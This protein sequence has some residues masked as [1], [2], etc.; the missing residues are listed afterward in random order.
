M[1]QRVALFAVVMAIAGPAHAQSEAALRDYFEGMPVMARVDLPAAKAG[2]DIYP[3]AAA[4]INNAQV[5]KQLRQSGVA[6]RRDDPITIKNLRVTAKSIELEF[7]H[8]DLRTS[9]DTTPVVYVTTEES[10]REKKLE[11][12][13]DRETDP[14]RR[15][16]MQQDL[17]ELILRR[18]REEARLKAAMAQLA[19]SRAREDSDRQRTAG[20]ASRFNLL[21][22]GGIPSRALSPEYL[23]S[24]L[25]TWI[26]FD[27]EPF[28]VAGEDNV[29]AVA[30]QSSIPEPASSPTE[31]RKGLTEA[32]L[33]RILGDPIKRE[34]HTLG[35]LHMEL[36]T[37][38]ENG[39]IVE[40]TMV[41][42]VLVRF[43]QSSY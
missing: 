6:I 29:P 37:F 3:D 21:F 24:A 40:A 13:I 4:A 12:D 36:L 14:A 5:G 38:R 28:P 31:L 16:K 9:S 34:P 32:E 19:A 30:R 26:D 8:S 11:Q 18:A 20:A 2:V 27:R 7:G 23:M 42:G 35:D 39:T 15:E 1:R 41:E 43:T 22:P 10:Q 25:K 33:Q 17:D